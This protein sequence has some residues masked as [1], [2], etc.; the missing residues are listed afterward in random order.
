MNKLP[1]LFSILFS[2]NSYAQSTIE[3][4]FWQNPSFEGEAPHDA[5]I[6]IGWLACEAFTTPDILPGVWGVY[7]EASDGDTFLGLITRNDGSWESI[8][9]RLSR[10][11]R[12]K[13]CYSF[14]F[15]LARATTYSGYN[16]PIKLRIWGSKDKCSKDQLLF[17]SPEIKNSFWQKNNC[18]FT[19]NQA[20]RYI[21]IEATI[22]EG[23]SSYQGNILIDNLSPIQA[24]PR[25]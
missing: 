20:I 4:I 21:I 10:T 2:L 23:N 3:P 25:A 12:K 16:T 14:N 6:P 13:E 8:T 1:I 9:Q 7:T 15:D 5:T 18:E 22:K 11:I 24:C 17:E 19:A